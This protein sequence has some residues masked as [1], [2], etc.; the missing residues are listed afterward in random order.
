MMTKK[1]YKPS[2]KEKAWLK[3]VLENTKDNGRWMTDYAMYRKKGNTVV[4]MQS[5]DEAA[6]HAGMSKIDI[7]R[8]INKDRITAEAIGF[9]FID[10]RKTINN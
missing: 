8:W 3:R 2:S 5:I 1:I 7:E 4:C 6:P 9:K 10:N